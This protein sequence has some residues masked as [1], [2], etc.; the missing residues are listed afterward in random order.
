LPSE[1]EGHTFEPCRVRHLS[2][3][4]LPPRTPRNR[5]RNAFGSAL[6]SRVTIRGPSNQQGL[7][8]QDISRS[9]PVCAESP[10]RFDAVMESPKLAE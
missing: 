8:V 9:P 6:I 5:P 1:G 7:A 2:G 3:M 4:E 10:I